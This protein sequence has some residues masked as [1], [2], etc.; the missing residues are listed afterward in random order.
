M[1][2]KDQLDFVVN[3]LAELL[4]KPQGNSIVNS[5]RPTENHGV[6]IYSYSFGVVYAFLFDF[7]IYQAFVCNSVW[8]VDSD[9]PLRICNDS[10]CG[11]DSDHLHGF[12]ECS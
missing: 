3:T 10:L 5:I 6:V 12:G 9:L 1:L 8:S 4:Q 2:V 7:S 11:D